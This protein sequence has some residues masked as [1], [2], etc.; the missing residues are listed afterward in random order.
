MTNWLLLQRSQIS[1]WQ[2][3]LAPQITLPLLGTSDKNHQ[4]QEYDDHFLESALRQSCFCTVGQVIL[5]L[6]NIRSAS[7]LTCILYSTLHTATLKPDSSLWAMPKYKQA[8]PIIILCRMLCS[9]VIS[10]FS[11]VKV[12]DT[13]K[14]AEM[15]FMAWHI[16]NKKPLDHMKKGTVLG[17]KYCRNWELLWQAEHLFITFSSVLFSVAHDKESELLPVQT[18]L[19]HKHSTILLRY[20]EHYKAGKLY[21]REVTESQKSGHRKDSLRTGHLLWRKY[22]TY[23]WGDLF[24]VNINT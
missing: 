9:A 8:S 14:E 4:H 2:G 5:R 10:C 6:C 12:T 18:V 1:M 23:R 19:S 22:S 16:S 7:L 15:V 20:L 3:T 17:Y 24:R 21:R 11:H 13:A